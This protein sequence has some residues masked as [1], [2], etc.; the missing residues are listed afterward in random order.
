M[1]EPTP[2]QVD[3]AARAIFLTMGW[4]HADATKTDERWQQL[5]HEAD[6]LEEPRPCYEAAYQAL[7][8]ALNVRDAS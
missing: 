7:L 1:N 6:L 8:A 2:S 4:P 3:A 5:R